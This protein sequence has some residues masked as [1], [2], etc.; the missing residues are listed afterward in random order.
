MGKKNHDTCPNC[1]YCPTCGRAN[2]PAPY[3]PQPYP[4]YRPWWYDGWVGGTYN[5]SDT[6]AGN[7]N[8]AATFEFQLP[9]NENW[10]ES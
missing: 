2:R 4:Y 3:W 8:T 5:T 1:G 9:I 10:S 6:I 7:D